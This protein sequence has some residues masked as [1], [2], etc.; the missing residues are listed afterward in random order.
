M[1]LLTVV[2]RRVVGGECFEGF[3]FR[4]RRRQPIS[5]EWLFG[6]PIRIFRASISHKDVNW[7][8]SRWEEMHS[9]RVLGPLMIPNVSYMLE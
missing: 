8:L 9:P 2:F 3:R 7:A 5:Y 1:F 4:A 6:G